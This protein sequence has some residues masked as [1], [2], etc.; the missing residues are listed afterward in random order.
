MRLS[1]SIIY[2]SQIAPDNRA[3]VFVIFRHAM[4]NTLSEAAIDSRVDSK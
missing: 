2:V 4:K 1:L 3:R